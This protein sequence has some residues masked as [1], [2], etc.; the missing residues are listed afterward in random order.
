L[1]GPNERTVSINEKL[2][3]A[4]GKSGVP[5]PMRLES[6]TAPVARR[7]QAGSHLPCVSAGFSR[8]SSALR[9]VQVAQARSLHEAV[10]Q[11]Q[12]TFK[13]FKKNF[14]LVPIMATLFLMSACGGGKEDSPTV[15]TLSAAPSGAILA[16]GT[17]AEQS[18]FWRS[19]NPTG[20]TFEFRLEGHDELVTAVLKDD[21]AFIGD[22]AV[23]RVR[24]NEVLGTQGQALA[25]LDASTKQ[26]QRAKPLGTGIVNAKDQQW[27]GG[28]IPYVID[29]AATQNTRNLFMAAKADYDA[30]TT[31]VK[32]VLRTNQPNYVR[33]I[34]GGG[35]FSFV[36]VIGGEQELSIGD[37]CSLVAARHEMGHALGLSHEMSR[38]DRDKWVRVNLDLVNNP[39]Q[40][41]IKLGPEGTPIGDYDF[42]SIMHYPNSQVNGRWVFEPKNGFPPDQ[43]GAEIVNTFTPGDLAAIKA[44]YGGGTPG[45]GGGG[46]GGGDGGTGSG[47]L[48]IDQWVSF[49]VKTAGY[50]NRY[51]GLQNGLGVTKI[52]NGNSAAGLKSDASFKVVRAIDGSA[53]YSFQSASF[54]G[55]YLRHQNWRLRV[56]TNDGSPLFGQDATFCAK[57]GLGGKGGVSLTSRNYPNAYIR[58]YNSQVWLATKGGPRAFDSARVYEDDTSWDVASPWATGAAGSLSGRA[59]FSEPALEESDSTR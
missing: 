5:F 36:G 45:G 39:S 18:A 31:S 28:V 12:G 38:Q 33:V 26:I 53:C 15:T 11:Q 10:Q 2:D 1:T 50:T 7:F 58:H 27:P 21:M 51:M 42:Q 29:S 34:S 30:K 59:S 4:L 41:E 13:L 46:G 54:P 19:Q 8:C 9:L 16:D 52:V 55:R 32:W 44:I 40:Y 47:E 48:T 6:L 14:S 24:G 43:V 3:K 20:Q 49:R 23:G 35:C 22:V 56:D 17:P 37:G 57:P 25:T